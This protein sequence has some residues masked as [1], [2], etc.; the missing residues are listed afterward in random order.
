MTEASANNPGGASASQDDFSDRVMR[1]LDGIA[2]REEFEALQAELSASEESR[3]GFIALCRQAR[4]I[5]EALKPLEGADAGWEEKPVLNEADEPDVMSEL[6]EEAL[7]ARRLHEIEDEA[8]KQLAADLRNQRQ[9]SRH[10]RRLAQQHPRVILVP[11]PI[12][13]LAVGAIAA[14]V[15]FAIYLVATPGADN[16][17]QSPVVIDPPLPTRPE[18]PGTPRYVA[19]LTE[20]SNDAVWADRSEGWVVGMGLEVGELHLTRG[21]LMVELNDGAVVTLQA[22][23]RFSVLGTNTTELHYGQ[24][25]ASVPE[26]G[27]GFEV[28]VPGG[29]VT[30]WGTSIAMIDASADARVDTRVEVMRGS[31]QVTPRQSGRRGEPMLLRRN[32]F[33]SVSSDGAE[34]RTFANTRQL[35]ELASPTSGLDRRHGEVDPRWSIRVPGSDLDYPAIVV[36]PSPDSTSFGHL[37]W[38]IGSPD[39]S[40]WIALDIEGNG[41]GVLDISQP[42]TLVFATTL[43]V[44]EQVDAGSVVL[45][46]KMIAD[47]RVMAIRVN[48]RQVAGPFDRPYP[49]RGDDDPGQYQRWISHTLESCFSQGENVIEFEIYNNNGATG[50]RIEM[51]CTAIQRYAEIE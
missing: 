48:G 20:L 51:E 22:P 8:N 14:L 11:K 28:F 17:G 1:Y 31:V 9:R 45:D 30:D 6:I 33:A 7:Q 40:Q 34:V 44:P 27:R 41:G 4:T 29:V 18:T 2:T 16:S 23:V 3:R 36:S 43:W 25:Q 46:L 12:A 13:A 5:S 24:V 49:N 10:A 37:H 42:A 35:V 19:T 26:S 38:W 50:T 32:Q 39:R 15:F 21:S 47:N